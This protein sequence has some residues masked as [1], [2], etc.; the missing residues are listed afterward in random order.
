MPCKHEV[1]GSIPLFSTLKNEGARG[2]KNERVRERESERAKG[3]GA[4]GRGGGKE[5][6]F[7][8]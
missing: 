4:K 5:K 2:R 6:M 7:F 8:I 3:E 1:K